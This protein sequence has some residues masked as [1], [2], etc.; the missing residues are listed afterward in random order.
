MRSRYTCCQQVHDKIFI[1]KEKADTDLDKKNFKAAILL[2]I[3]QCVQQTHTVSATV[4][5]QL[6][7]YG[8][9]ECKG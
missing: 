5:L 2:L 3:S 9:A 8:R 6:G 7:Q 4:T 1:T